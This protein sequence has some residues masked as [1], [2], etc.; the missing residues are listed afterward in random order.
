M[1]RICHPE[2][3]EGSA[4]ATIGIADSSPPRPR[5]GDRDE[6]EKVVMNQIST[7]G[8]D[9][10]RSNS[11]TLFLLLSGV[12]ALLLIPT[13]AAAQSCALCYTQASSAGARMIEALRS[14]ILVLIIPPTLMT[15]GMFFVIHRKT[16]QYRHREGEID[17]QATDP[18]AQ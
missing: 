15:V 11:S 6:D 1:F 3:S 12:I 18:Q 7:S 10:Q 4:V 14:G 8:R 9:H 5:R 16:Y 2:R 13:S 17:T